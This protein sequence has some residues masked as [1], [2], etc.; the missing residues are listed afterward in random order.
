MGYILL[1]G[2]ALFQQVPI[3]V[4]DYAGML[5]LD[6]VDFHNAAL[7][8]I[9]G[10]TPYMRH[11][12]VTP[13]FSAIPLLPLAVLPQH[14]AVRVLVGINIVLLITGALLLI[15][16][17]ELDR[18]TSLLFLLVCAFSPTTLMLVERGNIDGL[19]FVALCI[20]F[21]LGAT[22]PLAGAAVA[23]VIAMKVYPAIFVGPLLVRSR[24]TAITAVALLVL[25]ILFSA[26]VLP[27]GY[28]EFFA[29]QIRRASIPRLHENLSSLVL[30][31]GI[32]QLLPKSAQAIPVAGGALLYIGL[33]CTCLLYDY[34]LSAQLDRPNRNFLFA[35]YT[36]FCVNM[37]N[38][39]YAYSGVVLLILVAATGQRGLLISKTRAYHVAI[40]AGCVMIPALSF[41]TTLGPEWLA[42][43][44]VPPIANLCLLI[45][46]MIIRL[47]IARIVGSR[48]Y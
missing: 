20:M 21:A 30:F 19:I 12:F 41:T 48:A 27:G 18:P 26:V 33:L 5:G 37:P 38:V 44:F 34:R 47:E 23:I 39:V 40:L 15:R 3:R 17:F 4:I 13:P 36:V 24:R 42:M 14:D 32:G 11:R 46:V 45:N 29:N 9:S 2:V 10:Q 6:F 28:T 1:F 8:I 43:N 7:D 35:T 25:I 22:N 31:W 16:S